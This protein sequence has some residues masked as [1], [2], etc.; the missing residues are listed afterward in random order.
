[1]LVTCYKFI[2]VPTCREKNECLERQLRNVK[3][4]E[5]YNQQNYNC[6]M[7]IYSTS[8]QEYLNEKFPIVIKYLLVMIFPVGTSTPCLQV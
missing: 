5:S 6:S 7:A 3:L 8:S 1:M 2:C 4:S